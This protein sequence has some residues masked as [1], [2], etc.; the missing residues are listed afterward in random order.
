MVWLAI[1]IVAYFLLAFN[2]TLDKFFLASSK[3]KEDYITYTFYIAVLG[4]VAFILAPFGLI[5]PGWYLF[6][7][8][9]V[10][11]VVFV[12]ALLALYKSLD[13]G[14]ASR[15]IPLVGG[16]VAVFTLILSHI[17]L[18]ETLTSKQYL[19]FVFLVLGLL[20]VTYKRDA[21]AY[22]KSFN[23][24]VIAI[25]A[26]L[27][28]ALYYVFVRF[29]FL[30][31]NFITGF[32]WVRLGSFLVAIFFLFSRRLRKVIFSSGTKMPTNKKMLFFANQGMGGLG[33]IL[34]H[35]AVSLIN[36]ALINAMQGVQYVFVLIF[37]MMF[38]KNIQSYFAKK[39]LVLLL[40]RR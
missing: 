14:Q 32:V 31:T 34:I 16:A 8:C 13:L 40:V 19:A 33:T 24:Y 3:K 35:Y 20:L 4:M 26:A 12:L 17:Y 6:M 18:D 37:A 22:K 2:N 25:C 15:I 28:F 7:V 36:V 38:A 30:H 1:T 11:G 9:I 23:V 21:K 39:L 27:F 29:L 10:A 5:W